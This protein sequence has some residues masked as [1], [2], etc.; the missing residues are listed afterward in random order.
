MPGNY[1]LTVTFQGFQK[2]VVQSVT[3]EV[4]HTSSINIELKPGQLTE[5]VNVTA[6]AAMANTANSTIGQL[7]TAKTIENM[8]INGRNVYLM[9]QLAPGVIPINGAVNQTGAVNRPG[10]EV[11]AYKINGQRSG[12]VAYMLDG[13]PLTVDGYGVAVTSPAFT[14]A[15]DSVQEYRMETNNM[16]PSYGSPGTGLISMVSKSGTDRFHGS[17]FFFARPNALASNDPFLKASQLQRGAANQPPDFHRYQWG[18]S[19]GG[20]IRK[21][22]LFFFGDYEGTQTR[23]LETLTTTVPTAAERTGDFSAI[24]TIW[25]PF[26]VSGTGARQPFPGNVIPPS[27]LNPVALNM[28]K[29]IPSP[30]QAGVGKYF[31]NNYFDGS[32]FPNDAKKFDLRLDDYLSS[33]QQ[34]YGRYSFAQMETGKADHYHNGADPQYYSA[35]LAARTSCW[36]ITTPS[37]PPHFCKFGTP[38]PGT[39]S[40]SRFRTQSRISTWSR[41]A[42]P[43]RWPRRRWCATC[44]T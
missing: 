40:T 36:P 5:S 8:P 22:K 1:R 25:N 31:Q 13:S 18:G 43:L 4:D 20:P 33:K 17:G 34:I 39:R 30:N 35:P 23:T 21:G 42:F 7:I 3:V 14:P 24:P 16:F 38:S 15:M 2:A 6:E 10:V 9:V 12:S 11:S 19:F 44:P 41:R 26:A 27:S 28:Q 29:L 37:T 32:L